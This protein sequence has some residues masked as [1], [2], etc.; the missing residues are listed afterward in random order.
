MKVINISKI[1]SI[2]LTVILSLLPGCCK[3]EA[4]NEIEYSYI[5]D[6]EGNGYKTV[7]IGSQWWMAQNLRT[8][9]YNDNT[10]IS[11]FED[12]DHWVSDISGAYCWYFNVIPEELKYGAL[13]NW[14]AVN[15][16]KLCPTGWHVPTYTEWT[17]LIN[18]VGGYDAYKLREKGTANWDGN[19]DGT[20]EY[21][22]TA[23]PGGC[24]YYE[25]GEFLQHNAYGFWWSSTEIEVETAYVLEIF[26]W[27]E[28][29][30]VDGY[31]GKKNNGLSVRCMKD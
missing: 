21:G 19:P 7:K 6:I 16:G 29:A 11:Y 27:L 20:D 25:T 30:S 12:N 1:C 23:L 18:F 10:S 26:L 22:F 3:E 13:Y 17:T 24:R 28:Y 14:Y 15:T 2:A 8:T 5:D 31:W 4:E 9:K